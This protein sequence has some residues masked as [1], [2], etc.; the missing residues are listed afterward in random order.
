MDLT[1]F[2]SAST[3]R[4]VTKSSV[5]AATIAGGGAF[6][7]GRVDGASPPSNEGSVQTRRQVMVEVSP[8]RTKVPGTDAR[9]APDLPITTYRRRAEPQMRHRLHLASVVGVRLRPRGDCYRGHRGWHAAAVK[10][11]P[12]SPRR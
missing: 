6:F 10:T 9:R 2:A 8:H 12:W 7:Y 3:R 4:Q 1:T 5:Q 11:P